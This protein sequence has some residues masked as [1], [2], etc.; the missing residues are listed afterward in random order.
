MTDPRFYIDHGMIHDRLTGRHVTTDEP[1]TYEDKHI[2]GACDIND[3][4]QLLNHL[5]ANQSKPL[6]EQGCVHC[7]PIKLRAVL[8]DPSQS[9]SISFGNRLS[10]EARDDIV[11]IEKQ[12][13]KF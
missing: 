10:E 4:L 2:E 3:C 8:G 13:T 9:V 1:H 6:A 7:N 5:E 11:K 12:I